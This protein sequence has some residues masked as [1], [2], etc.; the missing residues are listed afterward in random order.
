VWRQGG[1][2]KPDDDAAEQLERYLTE[3]PD[4]LNLVRQQGPQQVAGALVRHRPARKREKTITWADA[5]KVDKEDA[6][7]FNPMIGDDSYSALDEGGARAR[8]KE[9]GLDWDTITPNQFKDLLARMMRD[10][11][12][13]D[14]MTGA[15]YV[16]CDLKIPAD[17]QR[18]WN[19]AIY[20]TYDRHDEESD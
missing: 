14:R 19:L 11:K 18:A 20:A 5:P 13:T 3:H 4:T 1:D 8:L 2:E 12:L 7:E 10:R 9:Q 17:H 15:C 6:A 16:F